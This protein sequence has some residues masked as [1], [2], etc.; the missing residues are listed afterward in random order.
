MKK[1]ITVIT[2]SLLLLLPP[3]CTAAYVIHLKDGRSFTTSEYREEGDQIKIERYGGVIGLPRDQIIDI[4]EIVDIPKKEVLKPQEN[5]PVPENRKELTTVPETHSKDAKPESEK[6]TN[7]KKKDPLEVFME[8]KQ[9][10]LAERE[11]ISQA[12]EE[13]KARNDRKEKDFYWNR[14]IQIQ[15]NLKQLQN[16]VA[17]ENDGVLPP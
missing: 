11:K 7:P 9:R 2:T 3:F 8:E 16:R 5:P 12:F 4:K 15:N 14:L 6:S 17:A 13:A 1:T 10:I